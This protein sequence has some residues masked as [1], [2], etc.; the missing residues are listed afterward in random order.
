M[1]IA[2]P[3]EQVTR[4]DE[5]PP[6]GR[7]PRR[8]RLL[9]ACSPWPRSP[10]WR[11][12][13]P[14]LSRL[15][16]P[17]TRPAATDV[18]QAARQQTVN[19]TTLD[20]QHLDRDLGR[21]LRGSTGDFRSQ[22]RAGTKDLTALVTENKAAS[23]GEVLDAGIVSDD[24]DS[25]RVLVVADSTVTNSASPKPQKRHYRLQLTSSARAAAGWSPTCTSW[26]EEESDM[27]RQRPV[28]GQRNRSRLGGARPPSRRR[29]SRRQPPAHRS[30]GRV[31][32]TPPSGP[33]QPAPD[34]GQ[35]PAR[36]AGRG[37][38]GDLLVLVAA[39]VALAL[40]LTAGLL[41]AAR[42][43]RG[44]GRAGADGGAGRRRV[45]RRRPALLRLPPPG[46]GLR[47]G[48]QGP[49]RQLRR[50]LRPHDRVGRPADRRS[51]S[52]PWSPPTSPRPRWSGP[53][54]TGSWSCCSSNQT[55][56]STRLEGPK[57]DLNRV[58]LRL[59]R[60]D[61]EW[62]VSKVVAL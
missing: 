55:T 41:A 6:A 4:P 33:A 36:P 46:P 15:S 9:L 13:P 12:P 16:P 2:Q 60:V 3:D 5:A 25:A 38:R 21:V 20:Y 40:A 61:G 56:T 35:P 34:A 24:A 59:D 44:P 30:A 58:Q 17:A 26:A 28:A 10:P 53:R 11:S 43:R 18:L 19:F 48:P 57:V 14:R 23:K 22:F 1:A 62:L 50:R 42:P 39:L 49:H 54:R 51:R 37:R 8:P 52:R 27:A 29:P 7:L 32:A 31:A 47:P 45:A